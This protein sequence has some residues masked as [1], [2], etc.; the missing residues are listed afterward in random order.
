MQV[1]NRVRAILLDRSERLMLIK[2]VKP[3]RTP[4]WVVPGGGVEHQD[5]DFEAALERE[6]MEE[7]GGTIEI[8]KLVKVLEYHGDDDRTV[9]QYLYLTRLVQYDL[10]KRS[11]PEFADP[12]R[13]EYIVEAIPMTAEAISKLNLISDDIK[14]FLI[15]NLNRFDYLPDLR[16]ALPLTG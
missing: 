14:D 8:E 5:A 16:S 15:A 6:I 1:N 2:R 3:N 9:R 10:S 11:G 13:G 12:T 7:L 4:Y